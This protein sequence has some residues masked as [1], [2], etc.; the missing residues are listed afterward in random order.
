MNRVIS[1]GLG[2]A[3]S[4]L[5]GL[6]VALLS[7]GALATPVLEMA[8]RCEQAAREWAPRL[9]QRGHDARSENEDRRP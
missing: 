5:R 1:L 3:A 8:G 9:W 7:V 6:S 2:L 4:C